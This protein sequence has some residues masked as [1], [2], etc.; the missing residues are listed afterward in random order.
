MTQLQTL[1]DKVKTVI[2]EINLL[3]SHKTSASII[4]FNDISIEINFLSAG[5]CFNE[6]IHWSYAL[7]IEV[8]GPNIKFFEDKM[9]INSK[10]GEYSVVP[11]LIHTIRTLNSHN[12][13]WTKQTDLNKRNFAENWY[14]QVI[15]KSKPISDEDY[16]VCSERLLSLIFDYLKALLDCIKI[17]A[18]GEFFE[19]VTLPDWQRRNDRHFTNYEFECVLVEVLKG[20]EIDMYLDATKITKREIDKWRL[21]IKDLKDG[22]NFKI[23]AA[24]IIT[25]FV[26]DQKYSPVDQKDL[27]DNGAEKGK[28]LMDLHNTITAEFHKNPRSKTELIA[29]A[30]EQNIL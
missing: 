15:N 28:A 4:F 5:A 1:H 26:L 30:K 13:D 27:L 16:N 18:A 6:L 29:W 11:S 22:F 7:F 8:C 21:H 24:R 12:L 9:K 17:E 19:E 3:T 2:N 10:L 14:G 20:Y 23:E 25:K